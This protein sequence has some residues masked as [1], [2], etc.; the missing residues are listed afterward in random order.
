MLRFFCIGLAVRLQRSETG[1]HTK[2]KSK[3]KQHEQPGPFS[4]PTTNGEREKPVTT[5]QLCDH[6]QIS[7]RTL[8]DYR[9]QRRIPFWK[10]NARN[11]RYRLSDVEAAL[12]G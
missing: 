3:A 12:A 2:M 7:S 9:A 1:N 4:P 5:K 11:F 6:L 10:I 8:A